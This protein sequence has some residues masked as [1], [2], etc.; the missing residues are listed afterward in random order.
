MQQLAQ[1]I[2]NTQERLLNLLLLL[3]GIGLAQSM[4]IGG[5]NFSYADIGFLGLFILLVYQHQLKIPVVLT[6]FFLLIFI[7]RGI[8]SVWYLPLITPQVTLNIVPSIL[9]YSLIA[10]YFLVGFSL[11]Q[12]PR[13]LVA[14][15][16]RYFIWSN[17]VI[18]LFGI[19]ISLLNLSSV[20]P[21]LFTAFR[22]R[23]LMNDPNYFSMLQL[24]SVPLIN[25]FYPEQ[26]SLRRTA[27][28]ILISSALLSGSKSSL[29]GLGSLLLI[30]SL[31]TLIK[32]FR[33]GQNLKLLIIS[34]TAGLFGLIGYLWRTTI[35][36]TMT[37]IGQQNPAL[38][39]ISSLFFTDN[40]LSGSGSGRTDAWHH[41]FELL[42][43]T[44][45]LGIGFNDYGQVAY[46][47]F[48][49][50]VI[51]HNTFLQ[52]A[53][54]WGLLFSLLFFSYLA[55]QVLRG[56]VHRD[57]LTIALTISLLIC[58]TYFLSISLN[59]SRIFWSFLG[60][61]IV[62]LNQTKGGTL[63]YE[64]FNYYGHPQR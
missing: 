62:Y 38:E 12:L 23:G 42:K 35:V 37:F 14:K 28:L 9:K 7:L 30:Y 41:A 33:H 20:F 15:L 59:N 43:S 29:F 53:V 48:G 26:T 22:Y 47:L 45:G 63:P 31:L 27:N 3:T 49:S 58:L 10:L 64:D 4:I 39:R 52:I 34:L 36:S 60:F 32:S 44:N 2:S 19:A 18:G 54:E 25:Y 11:A 5:L 50:P 17:V 8:V 21:Q 1:P 40:P 51:A 55:W 24:M 16:L 46:L 13:T 57:S 56:L 61:W 6:A